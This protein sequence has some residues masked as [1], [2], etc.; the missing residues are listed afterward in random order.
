MKKK[1]HHKGGKNETLL[2]T[3]KLRTD[4]DE[5]DHVHCLAFT[6][7]LMDLGQDLIESDEELRE[8]VESTDLRDM[9]TVQIDVAKKRWK[10]LYEVIMD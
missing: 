7:P 1:H 4:I 3:Y 10:R 6:S 5:G 2:Q 8:A 9:D